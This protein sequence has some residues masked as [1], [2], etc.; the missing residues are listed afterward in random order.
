MCVLDHEHVVLL[1]DWKILHQGKI[2]EVDFLPSYTELLEIR[3]GCLVQFVCCLLGRV[4]RHDQRHL[5]FFVCKGEFVF[6]ADDLALFLETEKWLNGKVD[7][8]HSLLGELELEKVEFLVL[9]LAH[10]Q[11]SLREIMK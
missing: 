4:L 8:V 10:P 11:K 9:V 7:F 3:E 6:V 1:T 2:L 5:K